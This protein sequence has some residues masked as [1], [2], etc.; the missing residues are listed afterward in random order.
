MSAQT[1]RENTYGYKRYRGIEARERERVGGQGEEGQGW[2]PWGIP[3][4]D[5]YPKRNKREFKQ[6]RVKRL[7]IIRGCTKHLHTHH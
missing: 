3:H 5:F 7:G 1:Y 6:S 4:G 2:A